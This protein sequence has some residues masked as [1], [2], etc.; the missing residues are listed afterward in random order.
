[1]HIG[2]AEKAS[3][4]ECVFFPAPGHWKPPTLLPSMTD[5]H[6]LPI[7]L[8]PKQE[9]AEQK[10]K[11]QDALYD[12]TLETMPVKIGDLSV[13]TFTKHFKYLGGYC[14]YFLKVNYDVDERF[15]QA[16][17]AMGALNHFWSDRS[18]ND[19]SKYLIF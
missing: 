17:S 10:Q 18:V 11:R 16:S 19:Y 4:T 14:S 2:T 5:P 15:S 12:D 7:T 13:I 8:Q 9:S 3:K 1:M 6:L